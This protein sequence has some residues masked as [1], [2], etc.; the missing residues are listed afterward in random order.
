M[1][2]DGLAGDIVYALAQEPDGTYWF[3]TNQGLS[4]YDGNNW[5]TWNIHNGLPAND[6]YAIAIAPSGDIWIGTRGGV[7]RMALTKP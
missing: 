4:R 6:V 3:G 2:K 7:T 1:Q 5:H